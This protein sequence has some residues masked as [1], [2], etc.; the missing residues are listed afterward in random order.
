MKFESPVCG[1]PRCFANAF[2]PDPF[3]S[4]QTQSGSEMSFFLQLNFGSLGTA[5]KKNASY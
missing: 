1:Q 2:Y 4:Q 3:I 5:T